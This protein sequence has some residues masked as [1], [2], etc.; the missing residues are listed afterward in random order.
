MMSNKLI[1]ELYTLQQKGAK[2][3]TPKERFRLEQLKLKKAADEAHQKE[4]ELKARIGD[5]FLRFMATHGDGDQGMTWVKKV[6]SDDDLWY[7]EMLVATYRDDAEKKAA[8]TAENDAENQDQSSSE[9]AAGVQQ[10]Q[11]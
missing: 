10:D 6:V 7:A 8:E 1:A 11:A 9:T 2:E 5:D 4:M 3:R